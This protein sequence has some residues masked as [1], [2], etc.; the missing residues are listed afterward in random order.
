MSTFN[1]ALQH[2]FLYPILNFNMSEIQIEGLENL[3]TLEGPAIFVANHRS[4]ADTA[5]ILYALPNRLKRRLAIAAAQDYFYKNKVLGLCVTAVLNT[6]AF[7]R[8]N[9]RKALIAAR[10][11]LK[12]GN[13][14]LI[15][16]EGGRSSRS[17]KR[18]F[19]MLAAQ[20]GLPVVPIAI[21]GT[22][23]MLPKGT[24]FPKRASIRI[25]FGEP[26][27]PGESSSSELAV[28]VENKVLHMQG[29]A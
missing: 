19:A 17:F 20:E 6:F 7:D 15:Y 5:V 21:S 11:F 26:V 13:S 8:T 2:I 18:G 24:F 22:H 4:H 1:I 10:Q 29:A 14:L 3:D 27:V 25:V 12:A 23:E 9:A 16:P 28:K